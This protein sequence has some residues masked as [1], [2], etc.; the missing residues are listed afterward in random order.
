MP[1]AG[2]FFAF[3]SDAGA[4]SGTGVEDF[5]GDFDGDFF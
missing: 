5:D 2:V 3:V 1:A 4:D